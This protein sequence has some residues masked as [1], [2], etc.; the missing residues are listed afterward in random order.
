MYAEMKL[1]APTLRPEFE[2]GFSTKE[3]KIRGA[4][5]GGG[6]GDLR[7]LFDL[8][9]LKLVSPYV[10]QANLELSNPSPLL[11]QDWGYNYTTMPALESDTSVCL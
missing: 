8:A 7:L 2:K 10:T 9:L 1:S 3:S 11:P 6:G 4:G 5:G